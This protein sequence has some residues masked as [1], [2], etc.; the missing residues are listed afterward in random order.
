MGRPWIHAAGAVTFTLHQRLKFLINDK[1]VIVCGEEDLLV[2]ELSSFRYIETYEKVN[3]IPLNCLEFEEVNSATVNHDQSSATILSSVTSAK[4]TLEKGLLAGWGKVVNVA[5]KREEFGIG[6]R[7]STYK[8][9]LKKKQFNPV[10]F[11]SAGF[12]SDHTVAVIGESSDNKP[13]TPSLVRRCPP[14]FKLTN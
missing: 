5:A 3:E 11:R 6:Y 12:Q 13:E 4:Q 8:A 1:L 10:K 9:S 14:R 7:P 2:S